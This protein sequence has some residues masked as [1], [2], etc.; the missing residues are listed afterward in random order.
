MPIFSR[1][2]IIATTAAGAINARG[3]EV[4]PTREINDAVAVTVSTVSK[5]TSSKFAKSIWA[6]FILG[7]REL[8]IG[9]LSV[10]RVNSEPLHAWKFRSKDRFL[11]SGD[12]D[13]TNGG[14]WEG[15]SPDGWVNPFQ[16]GAYGIGDSRHDDWPA[17]SNMLNY[18]WENLSPTGGFKD[19]VA[20][21]R[22]PGAKFYSSQTINLI[23]GIKMVGVINHAVSNEFGTTINFPVGTNGIVCDA[24]C[25]IDG[26]ALLTSDQPI[27]PSPTHG[28]TIHKPCA[29]TNCIAA[30]F[31]GH[32]FY[33]EAITIGN[34]RYV[35]D[36]TRFDRCYAIEN[37]KNGFYLL[38]SNANVCLV[39]NCSAY[40]NG[41]F[42]FRDDSLLANYFVSCHASGNGLGGGYCIYGGRTYGVVPQ[43]GADTPLT[44]TITPGTDDTVWFVAAYSPLTFG[45]PIPAWTSGT[46][47]YAGGAYCSL[48][49]L[50]HF[51]NCYTE[52]GQYGSYISGSFYGGVTSTHP[53]A[54][55]VGTPLQSPSG[56]RS[57]V[58]CIPGDTA[59]ET[60]T[61]Q[62]GGSSNYSP[63]L[64]RSTYGSSSGLFYEHFDVG[65]ALEFRITG[66]TVYSISGNNV[67]SARYN[68]GTSTPRGGVFGFTWGFAIGDCI[69]QAYPNTANPVFAGEAGRGW[70]TFN[71]APT[72]MKSPFGWNCITAGKPAS[73]NAL[74]A[75]PY[76]NLG[77]ATYAGL[78]SASSVPNG[79]TAIITDCNSTTLGA[80]A[81]GGGANRVRVNSDGTSWKIG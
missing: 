81:A 2:H 48:N 30:K 73:W 40:G 42:G 14:W 39:E 5:F 60:I 17:I 53:N 3:A 49:W 34:N 72:S 57:Y 77:V 15:Y 61:T 67:S 9:P 55:G 28:F 38:G 4:A 1:R 21:V 52:D 69:I 22:W 7:F 58:K 45:V 79:T 27:S 68:F 13:N 6:V 31:T 43:V 66:Q 41:E 23:Y 80:T 33:V 25:Y 76:P 64:I 54:F 78:P 65:N 10:H 18:C 70:F 12:I 37:N 24:P 29:I 44:A 26:I 50:T 63:N 16:F 56:F 35:A 75:A 71:S 20:S 19:S 62:I 32:G 8:G 11:A 59:H 46:T 47:F 51:S 74:Y 36:F